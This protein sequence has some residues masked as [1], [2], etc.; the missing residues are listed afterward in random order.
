MNLLQ[1]YT[2]FQYTNTH[3]GTYIYEKLCSQEKKPKTMKGIG[4]IT[5]LTRIVPRYSLLKIY[6]SFLR[7]HRDYG[8]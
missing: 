4:V 7:P 1:Q 2:C 8:G 6:K 3:L 5:I